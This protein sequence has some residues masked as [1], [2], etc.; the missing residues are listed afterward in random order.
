MN[1]VP[2]DPARFVAE[3]KEGEG[4]TIWICGGGQLATALFE[5]NLVDELIVKLNPIVFGSGIPMLGTPQPTRRLTLSSTR[6][7]PSGHVWLEYEVD[8]T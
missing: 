4:G 6:H 3:L 2:H 5:A 7:F 8:R 1:L